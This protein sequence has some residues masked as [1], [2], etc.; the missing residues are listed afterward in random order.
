MDIFICD[1]FGHNINNN[2]PFVLIYLVDFYKFL[3]KKTENKLSSIWGYNKEKINEVLKLRNVDPKNFL[4]LGDIIYTSTN[5]KNKYD[6]PKFIILG[7]KN[8]CKNPQSY[9]IIQDFSEGKIIEPIYDSNLYLSVGLFYIKDNDT[10]NYNDVGV[11]S[12][13][14]LKQNKNK[15]INKK[16]DITYNDLYLLSSIKVGVRTINKLKLLKRMF[17]L[18]NDSNNYLTNLSQKSAMKSLRN[19]LKQNITYNAQGEIIID[20]KCLTNNNSNVSFETCN[21]SNKQKWYLDPEGYIKTFTND[22][23]NCLSSDTNNLYV[24]DCNNDLDKYYKWIEQESNYDDDS[25]DYSLDEYQGKVV[26]LTETNNPWYINSNSSIQMPYSKQIINDEL[27]NDKITPPFNTNENILNHEN[28]MPYHSNFV[29]DMSKKD[30]GYGHSYADR[31]GIRCDNR[32]DNKEHFS[33]GKKGFSF[34]EIVFY[35]F[36]SIV[37]IVIIIF[38][39]KTYNIHD[40]LF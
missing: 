14:I 21:N 39:Y 13:H 25:S 22:G 37:I 30:L 28:M 35:V 38:C 11:V 23:V 29:M 32:D 9:N 18:T 15:I 20:D 31:L 1:L 6:N 27:Y 2:T 7:N 19:N 17:K 33:D 16:F 5:F 8:I 12:K 34:K 10:F 24:N 4:Y 26:V 40:K 3:I 36:I